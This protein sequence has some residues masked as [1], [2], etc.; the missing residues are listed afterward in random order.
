MDNNSI[1]AIIDADI[2][3]AGCNSIDDYVEQLPACFPQSYRDRLKEIYREC[4]QEDG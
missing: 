4:S 3:S 1:K 2:K